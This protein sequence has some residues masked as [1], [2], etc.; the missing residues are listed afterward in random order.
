MTINFGGFK[1][2]GATQI[3]TKGKKITKEP[4][5]QRIWLQ[6]TNEGNKDLYDFKTLIKKGKKPFFQLDISAPNIPIED[7]YIAL[8]GEKILFDD[9]SGQNISKIEL[10][11][12]KLLP[13]IVN[14]KN[15]SDKVRF[16]ANEIITNI[17]KK[18]IQ[19]FSD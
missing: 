12:K 2:A 11:R 8:K 9:I 5:V 16:V 1:N 7:S 19:T 18:L 4:L 10:I 6:L 13:K 17:T 15:I 3:L 14:D